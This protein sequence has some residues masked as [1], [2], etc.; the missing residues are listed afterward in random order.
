MYSFIN[1]ISISPPGYTSAD[2]WSLLNTVMDITSKLS[3]YSIEQIRVP[4]DFRTRQIAAHKSINDYLYELSLEVNES[5]R[6]DDR[7]FLY[8]FLSNQMEEADA[9]IENA[10]SNIQ[11]NKLIEVSLNTKPE[12]TPSQL[13]TEAFVMKCPVISFQTDDVF[14]ADILNCNLL[15][16]GEN[17]SEVNKNISLNNLFG[18]NS[19]TPHNAFLIEWKH[20]I[21]FAASKWNPIEQPIW[22]ELTHQTL[23]GLN[24][25]LSVKQRTDKYD[26]LERVGGIIAEMN[27]WRYDEIVTKKNKNSGQYRRIFQSR[28][29]NRTAYLSI[30]FEN[31]FGG[32]E[33]HNHRGNH[34]G[35]IDFYGNYNK[36]ADNSGNHDIE[37]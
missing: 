5:S 16:L 14:L 33:V 9:V 6:A 37:I 30:D 7:N 13:L 28:Y 4:S 21:Q 24:F 8:D 27:G 12:L 23:I 11:Y 34:Q 25:P 35:Q 22:N 26:E 2:S 36:E 19:F 32:F 31:P 3:D 10:L 15:T 29:G 1:D 17:N 18:N 20:K